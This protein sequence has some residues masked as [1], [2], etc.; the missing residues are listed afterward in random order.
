MAEVIPL[1]PS[2]EKI[3]IAAS[4]RKA[5]AAVAFVAVVIVMAAILFHLGEKEAQENAARRT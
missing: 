3:T 5:L 4:D 1:R 2:V